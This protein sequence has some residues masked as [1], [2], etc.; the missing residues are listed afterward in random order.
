MPKKSSDLPTSEKNYKF[1]KH[2]LT[3]PSKK[4]VCIAGVGAQKDRI[5]LLEYYNSSHIF[6]NYPLNNI[7][8][9]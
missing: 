2:R 5:R 7:I 9:L 4:I 1:S 8:K 3:P 6:N